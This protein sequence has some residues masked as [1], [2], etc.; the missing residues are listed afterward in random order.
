MKYIINTPTDS[1]LHDAHQDTIREAR[2]QARSSDERIVRISRDIAFGATSP[3]LKQSA[4][5]NSDPI[6]GP[7]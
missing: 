1:G 3:I 6:S 5:Y 7:S 2:I 4:R